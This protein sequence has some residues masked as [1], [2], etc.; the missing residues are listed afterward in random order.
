MKLVGD[1]WIGPRSNLEVI[2]FPDDP[3]PAHDTG[4]SFTPS[5][6]EFKINKDSLYKSQRDHEEFMTGAWLQSEKHPQRFLRDGLRQV[7]TQILTST[8]LM[9]YI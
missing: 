1:R 4:K 3:W 7:N 8:I 5:A 2:E 9:M 6:N